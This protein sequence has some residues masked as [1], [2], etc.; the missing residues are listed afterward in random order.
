LISVLGQLNVVSPEEL[1]EL[2]Q[3]HAARLLLIARAIGE[4]AEDA[5]QDA[6]VRLAQQS[7]MPQEP[8]AWLVRVARNQLIQWHRSGQRRDRR[9][10][11]AATARGWF[12]DV[13]QA[14]RLDADELTLSLKSLP[15]IQ[16]QIVVLHLWGEL[17]FEQI[18]ETVALSRA[19]AHRRYLEAINTLRARFVCPQHEG[20]T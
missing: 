17:S 14:E 9:D 16:R 3:R 13:D 5:V 2:W 8:L 4:P 20:R 1:S 10:K 18:A 11:L 6:F 15:D 7:T 19:T 12:I